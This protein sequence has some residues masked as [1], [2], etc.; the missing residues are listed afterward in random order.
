MKHY[1]ALFFL[2]LPILACRPSVYGQRTDSTAHGLSFAVRGKF[3]TYAIIEDIYLHTYNIGAELIWK[4][5]HSVGIDA[6]VF[7]WRFQTDFYGPDN[8]EDAM[9]DQFEKRSYLSVDYK[10]GFLRRKQFV[11]YANA[12]Y[13]FGGKYR[14]WYRN[15]NLPEVPYD[16]TLQSTASGTFYEPGLGVGMKYYFGNSRFGV[17]LSM[18]AVRRFETRN[19]ENYSETGELT[20]VDD[21]NKDRNGFYVRLN[22]F[23]HFRR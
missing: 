21:L 6:N 1:T 4:E 13:K 11:L 3:L 7:R 10:F 15:Y 17:D 12:L 2:L 5:R 8:S 19:E 23:Y 22:F 18:N 20:Y 14:M 16:A 9:Y